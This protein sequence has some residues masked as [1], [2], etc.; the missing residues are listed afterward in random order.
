M[1]I[2]VAGWIL[3]LLCAASGSDAEFPTTRKGWYA[4]AGIIIVGVAIVV[5]I[6]TM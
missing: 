4:L 3:L 2:D 6:A 5:V 1:L